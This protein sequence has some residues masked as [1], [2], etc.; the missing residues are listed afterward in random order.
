MEPESIENNNV[1]SRK[2]IIGI[3]LVVLVMVGAALG[4]YLLQQQQRI[5]SKASGGSFVNA[6]EIKDQ[7]GNIISCDTATNPP[8]CTTSTLEVKVR[9][10]DV[11]PLLP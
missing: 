1:L 11:N 8:T 4:I 10:K 3:A 2:Q 6:F 9:V 7:N 5:K